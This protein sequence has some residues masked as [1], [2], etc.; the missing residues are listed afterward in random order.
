MVGSATLGFSDIMTC[1]LTAAF[2]MIITGC[3]QMRDA[4][5]FI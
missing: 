5:P 2:L 1:S 3:L 4:L